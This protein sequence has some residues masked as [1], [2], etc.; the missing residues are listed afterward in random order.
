MGLLRS[1]PALGFGYM[2]VRVNTEAQ[3]ISDQITYL[4]K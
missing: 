4:Y 3:E 1:R 2:E